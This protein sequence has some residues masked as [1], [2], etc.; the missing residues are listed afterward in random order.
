[1][2]S[3]HLYYYFISEATWHTKMCLS[4]LQTSTPHELAAVADTHTEHNQL[5]HVHVHSCTCRCTVLCYTVLPVHIRWLSS[6]AWLYYFCIL[7]KLSN[8]SGQMTKKNYFITQDYESTDF[9]ITRKKGLFQYT[10]NK[11]Q[12]YTV[13]LYLETAVHVSSGTSTHHQQYI[14]HLVFVTLLLLPV[15]ITEELELFHNSGR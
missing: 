14:Q 12:L 10:A 3:N 7:P 2:V 1:M 9:C 4:V 5:P 11:M 6:T 13:H 8:T 15:A